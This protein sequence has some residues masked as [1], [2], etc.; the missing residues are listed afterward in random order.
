M[1]R[2]IL[3]LAWPSI[4]TNVTT[5]LMA[6]VDLAIVGHLGGMT[7]IGAVAMGG[8][9]FNM[10]Y[11]LT[12]FLRMGTSGFTAQAHGCGDKDAMAGTLARALAVALVL[13]LPMIAFSDFI[14]DGMQTFMAPEGGET[15]RQARRY[16]GISIWGAP[17]V[18]AT[19]SL[20]G[21]FT[22]MQ[23]TR[24][25]LLMAVVQ[26]VLNIILSLAL[27]YT[28]GLDIEGVALGTA[29]SQW[30]GAGTGLIVSSEL[31]RRAA[32]PSLRKA[33][34]H[35]GVSLGRF[36]RVNGD[37]FLRTLCLVCVTLWF[38]RQGA[39]IG[40]DV[41]AA[42]A[43]LMQLFMLFS[44]FMDGFAFAGEALAGHFYGASDESS[45]RRCVRLL[46]LWGLALSAIVSLLY[47]VG[48]DV[49]LD[50]LTDDAT[51]IAAAEQYLPWA[52]AVP[53][54]GFMAFVWDGVF[55]GLTLTRQM[56]ASM[57]AATLVF[58]VIDAEMPAFGIKDITLTAND[59][60]WLA[61]N[62]YLLCRGLVQASIFVR[63]CNRQ[64]HRPV[65]SGAA[66]HKNRHG[67]T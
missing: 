3:A 19:Y 16:F 28:F 26:N 43:L 35:A 54:C 6:M 30:V 7:S 38:T 39:R 62:A 42:N 2:R 17:A 33:I 45:L 60:L 10:L 18:L 34:R 15:V 61:F 24:P 41:L 64:R 27:V 63:R 1:S 65:S 23:D 14:A 49:I 56:L 59:L 20:S 4:A 31:R 21:W 5:P 66:I 48:G 52:S 8:A 40:A 58:F 67:H 57:A 36:F 44:F 53:I 11:W 22:G 37:I 25:V 32:L 47:A 13:S 29:V 50:I 51:V 9:M 55:V 46:L 12:N